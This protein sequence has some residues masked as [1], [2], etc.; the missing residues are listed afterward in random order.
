MCRSVAAPATNAAAIDASGSRRNCS[1]TVA[2]RVDEP[3][4]GSIPLVRVEQCRRQADRIVRRVGRRATRARGSS[5]NARLSGRIQTPSRHSANRARR[6]VARDLRPHRCRAGLADHNGHPPPSG[7]PAQ[8]R[9]EAGAVAPP[10]AERAHR[11][12]RIGHRR[13]AALPPRSSGAVPREQVPGCHP[14]EASHQRTRSRPRRRRGPPAEEQRRHDRPGR[15][16]PV[17]GPNRP[18]RRPDRARDCYVIASFV[19]IIVTWVRARDAD[20][21]PDPPRRTRRPTAPSRRTGSPHPSCARS[22]ARS[23]PSTTSRISWRSTQ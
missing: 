10:G 2:S 4:R 3:S 18:R 9:G 15:Q 1:V 17:V 16:R 7:P 5:T 19:V 14:E 13:G 21:R 23:R 6:S 12:G 11:P 8:R 22:C 20:P